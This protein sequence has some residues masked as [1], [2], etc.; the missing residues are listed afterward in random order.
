VL[1][2][3]RET[4]SVRWLKLKHALDQVLKFLREIAV[5]IFL[6]FAMGL[7]KEI[8]SVSSKH[9][10][11]RIFGWISLIKWRML[12]YQNEQNGSGS[13]NVNSSSL[14]LLLFQELWGHV[15]WSS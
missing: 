12:S 14:V 7:P 5:S 10:I 3:L 15:S 11:E 9:F 13:K 4:W 8:S 1:K 6:V 2:N